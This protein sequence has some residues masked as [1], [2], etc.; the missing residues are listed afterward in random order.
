VPADRGEVSGDGRG[1]RG[2]AD[3]AEEEDGGGGGEGVKRGDRRADGAPSPRLGSEGLFRVRDRSYPRH[4]RVQITGPMTK[5]ELERLAPALDRFQEAHFFLHGL[6]DYYHFADRFRWHLNAFLRALKEVPHLISMGLQNRPGFPQWYREKRDALS[7]DPLVRH[8]ADRRDFVVHRGMLKPRSRGFIGITEGRGMKLGIGVPI[9]PLSDSDEAMRR[10]LTAAAAG[11]DF[12]EL[13]MDDEDSLP[14]VE[15][16]WG[17]EP[18]GDGD[19]VDLCAKAWLR[20]GT[21]VAAVMTELGGP[22]LVPNLDCR[23]PIDAVRIRAYDR[24][25][26]REGIVEGFRLR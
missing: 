22:E 6:E 16:R 7:A 1:L 9:D 5:D 23:H 3:A 19:L 8:L 25:R 13:L 2:E 18:F 20:T 17:L 15:R 4:F 14:A 21:L 12:L 11:R 24:A 26:L 10:Y